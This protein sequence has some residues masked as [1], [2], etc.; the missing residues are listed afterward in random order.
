MACNLPAMEPVSHRCPGGAWLRSLVGASLA[1]LAEGAFG[2][3]LPSLQWH[4][5]PALPPAPGVAGAFGGMDNGA[6]I[7]AGGSNFQPSAD[8]DLWTAPKVWHRDCFILIDPC[9]AQARWIPAGQLSEP[10]GNGASVPSPCGLVCLGG[11]SGA[12]P[13]AGAFLL[14][15]QDGALRQTNLPDLPVPGSCG[16]AAVIGRTVFYLA[17]QTGRGLETA[18]PRLWSLELPADGKAFERSTWKECSPLPGAGRAFAA[19]VAQRGARETCLYAIGGRLMRAGED[20]AGTVQPLREVFEYVPS[21]NLWRRRC[22]APVAMMAA[23]VFAL[24]SS[25]ILVLGGDDGALLAKTELL[26]SS[27]PGFPRRGFVYDTIADRWSQA[28]ELPVNQV[29]AV[30]GVDGDEMFL[31]TGETK[32][33]HRTPAAWRI[34]AR[35]SGKGL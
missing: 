10:K 2:S 11:E 33:R 8:E 24:G 19:F 29:A 34:T 21:Q 31:V 15:W 4:S 3:E 17:G 25:K 16:A 22:D 26:K 30:T 5:L 20:G 1:L 35:G 28:V 13:T 7:V 6:L 27:H 12:L 18:D 23:P 32:P 14:R 9:S